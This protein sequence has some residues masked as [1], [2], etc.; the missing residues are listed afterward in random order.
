MLPKEKYYFG[1]LN[2]TRKNPPWDPD[3]E[4]KYLLISLQGQI[5]RILCS[6]DYE[7]A[8]IN[9][10]RLIYRIIYQVYNIYK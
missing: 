8:Q 7:L 10:K 1:D 6:T 2:L 4:N 5:S 3:I 9:S